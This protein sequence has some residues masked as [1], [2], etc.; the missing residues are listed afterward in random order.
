[1]TGTEGKRSLRQ[2]ELLT[3]KNIIIAAGAICIIGGGIGMF[4]VEPL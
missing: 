2:G 3:V 4:F 1:M